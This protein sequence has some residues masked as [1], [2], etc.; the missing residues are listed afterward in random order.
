MESHNE[1]IGCATGCSPRHNYKE[2]EC[3]FKEPGL[4]W[5]KHYMDEIEAEEKRKNEE[6]VPECPY[7]RWICSIHTFETRECNPF[8]L[9]KSIIGELSKAMVD[10]TE[11]QDT[12]WKF[13]GT[14]Y[15]KGI[16][17][18]FYVNIF[19]DK[20]LK[21]GRFLVEFHRSQGDCRRFHNLITMVSQNDKPLLTM[22]DVTVSLK[23]KRP[24][25]ERENQEPNKKRGRFKK[26]ATSGKVPPAMP[27]AELPPWEIVEEMK[28]T[29]HAGVAV[30]EDSMG[31]CE[32]CGK[33]IPNCFSLCGE[34]R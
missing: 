24:R 30:Y 10:I 31:G 28:T 26:T 7:P 29:I 25:E 3:C 12:V 15:A 18:S 2:D 20:S 17:T 13:D 14:F 33:R 21:S 32:D 1:C 22:K 19:T 5:C 34:C 23:T 11:R 27:G 4:S 9:R 16:E 6:P 8:D